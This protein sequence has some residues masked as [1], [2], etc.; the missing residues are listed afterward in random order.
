LH[1]LHIDADVCP[2]PESEYKPGEQDMH[3]DA[4]VCPSPEIEYFPL[5]QAIRNDPPGQ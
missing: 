4:D 5:G 3:T 2:S 1:H